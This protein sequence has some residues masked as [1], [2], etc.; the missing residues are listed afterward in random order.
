[1]LCVTFSFDLT[2]YQGRVSI[3]AQEF[4]SQVNISF[5]THDARF[6]FIHIIGTVKAQP[7][8][9]GCMATCGRDVTTP[10]L[11]ASALEAPSKTIVH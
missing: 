5:K 10:I 11:L 6:I 8:S 4:D 1:M 9:E 2:D 3:Y 7:S